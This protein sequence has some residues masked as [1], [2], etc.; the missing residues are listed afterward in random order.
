MNRNQ[1]NVRSQ[2]PNIRTGLCGGDAAG[3]CRRA[4]THLMVFVNKQ[5]PDIV[6]QYSALVYE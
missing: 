6:S 4:E 1:E 5:L 3:D 2:S